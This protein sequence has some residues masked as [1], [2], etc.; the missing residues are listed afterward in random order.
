MCRR[1]CPTARSIT[2]SKTTARSVRDLSDGD[3]DTNAEDV[4]V[5]TDGKIVVVGRRF[6][7]GDVDFFIHLLS[8]V[9]ATRRLDRPPRLRRNRRSR[10]GEAGRAKPGL[11]RRERPDRTCGRRRS[12]VT[13]G[14]SGSLSTAS[15]S[16]LDFH[17]ALL[18]AR[19]YG[20]ERAGPG[21]V[22]RRQGRHRRT[23]VS[24]LNGHNDF[25]IARFNADGASTRPSAAA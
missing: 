24:A 25:F 13:W 23:R 2:A 8:R 5:Q 20:D 14:S 9:A 19:A 16:S 4:S 17:R 21:R 10:R 15:I 11:R 18:P 3:A 12:R 1:I 22:A 7:L 6:S